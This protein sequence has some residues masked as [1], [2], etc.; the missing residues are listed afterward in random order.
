MF[1]ALYRKNNVFF[2][3]YILFVLEEKNNVKHR[4]MSA[5]F[6][7]QLFLKKLWDDRLE[8]VGPQRREDLHKYLLKKQQHPVHLATQHSLAI[9][10]VFVESNNK[11]IHPTTL[12]LNNN[13]Q[14][15]NRATELKYRVLMRQTEYVNI[16]FDCINV[17]AI[18]LTIV[19]F[20]QK[21][22]AAVK[23]WVPLLKGNSGNTLPL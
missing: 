20:L 18:A 15:P 12:Q 4:R 5:I 10:K 6:S 21:G 16:F 13:W 14:D 2:V 9:N 19:F 1:W 11:R 3:N 8:H 17:R 23:V 7:Y 22:G